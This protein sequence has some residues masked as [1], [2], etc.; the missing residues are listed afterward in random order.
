M[1]GRAAPPSAPGLL[2]PSRIR[3]ADADDAAAIAAIYN[4]GIADRVATFETEPRSADERAAWLASRGQ[5]HPVLVA[6]DPAGTVVGWASLNS[7][8]ARA[9]YDHVADVSIYV[10]RDV[11]GRGVGDALLNGLTARAR[12]IGYHKL[13]LA[14]FP[15]NEAALRL[16]ARHGFASVGTYH[17]QGLLDGRWMDVVAMELLLG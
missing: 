12:S 17:E 2:R 1:A 8:S 10:A 13:V 4:E 9:A 11:R 15:T 7:F 6:V 14:T 16:Y 5:R 3:D